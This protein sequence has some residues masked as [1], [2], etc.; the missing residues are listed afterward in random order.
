MH[1][2]VSVSLMTELFLPISEYGEAL[3]TMYMSQFQ[4]V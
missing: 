4:S 2:S 1:E 3:V